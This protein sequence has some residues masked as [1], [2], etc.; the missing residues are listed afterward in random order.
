MDGMMDQRF[1]EVPGERSASKGARSVRRGAVEDTSHAVRW[2][3]TL[4]NNPQYNENTMAEIEAPMT[5]KPT[6]CPHCKEFPLK[7]GSIVVC[8]RCGCIWSYSGLHMQPGM[9]S[10]EGNCPKEDH[11]PWSNEVEQ[12]IK[13][14]GK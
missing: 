9:D 5:T 4:L 14:E 12:K 11:Q 8:T 1:V 10:P 3:P 6:T 2:P 7:V 13:I